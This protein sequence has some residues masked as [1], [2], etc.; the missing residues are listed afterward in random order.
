METDID[1]FSLTKHSKF[2][3]RKNVL[4]DKIS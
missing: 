4:I 1:A 2:P 3:K